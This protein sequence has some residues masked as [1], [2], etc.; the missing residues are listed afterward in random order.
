MIVVCEPVNNVYHVIDSPLADLLDGYI[1]CQFSHRS[2]PTIPVSWQNMLLVFVENLRCLSVVPTRFQ[3]TVY[4]ASQVIGVV[5]FTP[6]SSRANRDHEES[7][8]G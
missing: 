3:G 4:S 5:P 8:R 1:R 2:V 7:P 6:L